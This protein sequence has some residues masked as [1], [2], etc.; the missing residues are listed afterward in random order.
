MNYDNNNNDIIIYK[1]FKKKQYIW[2][3]TNFRNLKYSQYTTWHIIILYY[4]IIR[5]IIKY[6]FNNIIITIH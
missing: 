1:W 4:I 2:N 3:K 6:I 5:E